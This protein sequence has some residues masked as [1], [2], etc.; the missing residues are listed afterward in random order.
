MNCF[1]W[2]AAVF[3]T[4]VLVGCAQPVTGQGQAPYAPES[5]PFGLGPV[6]SARGLV[7]G[8]IA[9]L[10]AMADGPLRLLF[11]RVLDRLDYWLTLA[12]LRILDA[13]A[14]PCRRRL[15]ISSEHGIGS[16]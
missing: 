12:R 1:R 6:R 14:G 10:A 13:L 16:G 5:M 2:R 7:P 3:V 9:D 8:L 11:W 4:L 15:P